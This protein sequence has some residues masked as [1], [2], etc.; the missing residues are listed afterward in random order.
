MQNADTVDVFAHLT[1]KTSNVD[2]QNV[3]KYIFEQKFLG[4]I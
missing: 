1:A 2:G 4:T 3:D